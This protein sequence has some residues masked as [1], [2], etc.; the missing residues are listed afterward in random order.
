VAD[1]VSIGTNAHFEGVVL[2]KKLI[3]VKTGASAA[4]RLLSQTAITLEMNGITEPAL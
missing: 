1:N 4:G 2:G 3:A